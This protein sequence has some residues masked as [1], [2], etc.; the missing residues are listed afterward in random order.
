MN[1]ISRRNFIKKT[2]CSAISTIPIISYPSFFINKSYKTT[3]ITVL[4]TNDIHSHI[5]AFPSN[6]YKFPNMGGA[7]S[8]LARI[9]EIRKEKGKQNVLLFD[10]GDIIQGT[11]YFNYFKGEVDFKIMNKMEYSAVTIGNHDFDG[12]MEVLAQNIKNSNF[13]FITSNY[14]FKNTIIDKKT[15]KYKIF[16]I[17]NIKIGVLGIGIQLKGL[18]E[19]KMYKKTKYLDPIESAN[20]T[21]EKLK[22]KG[23]D[24]IICLSHLGLKYETNK[25]SDIKLA[26][27]T[28]NINLIIGGHTHTFMQKPYLIKNKNNK[29][30]QITQAGWAG[31][32]LGRIDIVFDK[33]KK[34]KNTNFTGIEIIN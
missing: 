1:K 19:E 7:S 13:P 31:V 5:E 32:K 22:N 34:I 6:H 25:M 16:K 12:G 23:C 21:A 9:K 33:R 20:L 15:L 14:Q 27:K 24:Y 17:K 18:V 3:E 8:R 4:H 10:S 26:Q 28:E 29:Q 11:P 30:V 2:G